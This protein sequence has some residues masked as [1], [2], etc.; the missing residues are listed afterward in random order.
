LFKSIFRSIAGLGIG[1]SFVSAF[2]QTEIQITFNF[3]GS[4]PT[5]LYDTYVFAAT[6][7]SVTSNVVQYS[8]GTE[9][10][11]DTV[12]VN[13]PSASDSYSYVAFGLYDDSAGTHVAL[14]SANSLAGDAW[15]TLFPNFSESSIITDL[16][17]GNPTVTNQLSSDIVSWYTQVYPVLS[18]SL[19]SPS[20]ANLTGFSNG[21]LIG[22]AS[23]QMN[24]A[25]E[26]VSLVAVL[27][28]IP[29]LRRRRR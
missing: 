17:S 25:P 26:P 27:G 19:N 11:G 24:P 3:S 20:I 13:N 5:S 7:P 6:D 18:Y 12:Y 22:S 10:Q 29:L 2:G 14:S 9:S 28:L 23:S 8:E 15:S 4:G 16:E 1:L 21:V